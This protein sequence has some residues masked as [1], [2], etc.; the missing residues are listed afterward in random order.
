VGSGKLRLILGLC[1][2]WEGQ[3]KT[4]HRLA[5]ALGGPRAPL[6]VKTEQFHHPR[7]FFVLHPINCPHPKQQLI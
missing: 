1:Q 6:S 2:D 5:P 4:L 3:V 7:G